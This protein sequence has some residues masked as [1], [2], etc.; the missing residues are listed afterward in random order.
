[1]ENQIKISDSE[2]EI[3]S[4]NNE[5]QL[6]IGEFLPDI[7][8]SEVNREI[9]EEK[10]IYETK[11]NFNTKDN[12]YN[13]DPKYIIDNENNDNENNN[14][15]SCVMYENSIELSN[16]NNLHHLPNHL[17]NLSISNI[18]LNLN[19]N[20]NSN[21]KF[22][23]K[24]SLIDSLE[25]NSLMYINQINHIKNNI[26]SNNIDYLEDK[27][28][29]RKCH[30]NNGIH[31]LA[32]HHKNNTN[33]NSN[34]CISLINNRNNERN[35]TDIERKKVR[36][37]SNII[38]INSHKSS[39]NN[40]NISYVDNK[41]STKTSS[42]MEFSNSYNLF[43]EKFS[44]VKRS[45]I[46]NTNINTNI[47]TNSKNNAN[48]DN[49]KNNNLSSR[50]NSISTSNMITI[51]TIKSSN[52]NNTNNTVT[53]T[54]NGNGENLSKSIQNIYN[55][56]KNEDKYKHLHNPIQYIQTKTEKIILKRQ[57]N[58]NN[59]RSKKSTIELIDSN[60]SIRKFLSHRDI[61]YSNKSSNNINRSYN[62]NIINDDVSNDKYGKRLFSQQTFNSFF[63]VD[64]N[65]NNNSDNINS[66]NKFIKNPNFSNEYLNT[67]ISNYDNRDNK[68]NNDKHIRN[69]CKISNKHSN[70]LF[71]NYNKEDIK[72][73]SF[74]NT[75]NTI[76]NNNTNNNNNSKSLNVNNNFQQIYYTNKY[77]GYIK[78]DADLI[79]DCLGN[80]ISKINKDIKK[81]LENM[82]RETILNR[83]KAEVV[84]IADFS[85][86]NFN[87]KKIINNI[88]FF[89]ILTK[90]D[91]DFS[92]NSNSCFVSNC[93]N[94]DSTGI[95]NAEFNSNNNSEM[96]VKNK[97]KYSNL[98]NN[99]SKYKS[100]SNR[101]FMKY[102]DNSVNNNN[103]SKL[104]H[105]FYS[106]HDN[107]RFLS[108]KAFCNTISN[109]NTIYYPKSNYNNN[110]DAVNTITKNS[111][112]IKS[113]K[114]IKSVRSIA[115]SNYKKASKSL[116]QSQLNDFNFKYISKNNTNCISNNNT[117]TY[118]HDTTTLTKLNRTKTHTNRTS[119]SHYLNKT[120]SSM[121]LL[122]ENREK[123]LN[124]KT[125]I[126]KLKERVKQVQE[127]RYI[128][129][130][131]VHDNYNKN[132]SINR[133]VCLDIKNNDLRSVNKITNEETKNNI[134]DD[135]C[136]D[137]LIN[138]SSH[139][140]H[141]VYSC[142]NGE[143]EN[144]TIRNININR[145][146]RNYDDKNG[147]NVIIVGVDS[148]VSNKINNI[149]AIDFNNKTS[150]N[151]YNDIKWVSNNKLMI[152]E[153][154]KS[155][156]IA[157]TG[158]ISIKTNTI[159]KHSN[160]SLSVIPKSNNNKIPYKKNKNNINRKGFNPEL[161]KELEQHIKENR[162]NIK[163][164]NTHNLTLKENLNI[165]AFKTGLSQS[166]LKTSSIKSNINNNKRKKQL[167][168]SYNNKSLNEI[169]QLLPKT[170]N[171]PLAKV[172]KK[173]DTAFSSRLNTVKMDTNTKSNSY[174]INNI[175]NQS[176]NENLSNDCGEENI[177][178]AEEGVIVNIHNYIRLNSQSP[179][180]L[181]N[182][183]NTEENDNN[184]CNLAFDIKKEVEKDECY[185]RNIP[186]QNIDINNNNSKSNDSNSNFNSKYN[187]ENKKRIIIEDN[188][189]ANINESNISQLKE[190]ETI[191]KSI[192]SNN[193][194]NDSAS[195]NM[196]SNN[197]N[198]DNS[199]G[200]NNHE[201]IKIPNHPQLKKYNTKNSLSK[202]IKTSCTK[203]NIKKKITNN[204]KSININNKVTQHFE[205]F[206]LQ[207]L[208]YNVYHEFS[209][210][211]KINPNTD[212]LERMK[213]YEIKTNVK[214][215]KIRETVEQSL[216]KITEKE[217]DRLVNNL[218][219]DK[220]RRELAKFQSKAKYERVAN[221]Q[222]NTNAS[223]HNWNEYY[224]KN[225]VDKVSSAKENKEKRIKE[226][227]ESKRI[228]EERRIEEIKKRNKIVSKEKAEKIF[229]RLSKEKVKHNK[230]G[231]LG[232]RSDICVNNSNRLNHNVY[233][234][235]RIYSN[236]NTYN[237]FLENI[238][239][240]NAVNNDDYRIK[241]DLLK[242]T[243]NK[244]KF[245]E[246][247]LKKKE[248]CQLLSGL[249]NNVENN[250]TNCGT[251]TEIVVSANNDGYGIDSNSGIKN[252]ASSNSCRIIQY[253]NNVK[254]N[255]KG[256]SN[257]TNKS[258]KSNS[259][260]E[261]NINN[262]K[263]K[264]SHLS[265][266]SDINIHTNETYKSKEYISTLPDIS[267][268][269]S[270]NIIK[271]TKFGAI[272][273]KK[274]INSNLIDKSANNYKKIKIYNSNSNKNNNKSMNIP[275][276]V[277]YNNNN[278]NKKFIKNHMLNKT[279]Y[280]NTNN[281][282]FVKINE[283]VFSP[284]SSISNITT[285]N[286]NNNS[287]SNRFINCSYNNS[288]N[289]KNA[290]GLV[291]FNTKNNYKRSSDSKIKTGTSSDRI[292][293]K[294]I[295]KIEFKTKTNTNKYP[296]FSEFKN[297]F[298][299]HKNN[300]NII[301][302]N[303]NNNNITKNKSSFINN[304]KTTTTITNKPLISNTNN[305]TITNT[306]KEVIVNQSNH[307]KNNS[308]IHEVKLSS[309]NFNNK[310]FSP[311][312]SISN[313]LNNTNNINNTHTSTIINVTKADITKSLV[314][315][316]QINY[317]LDNFFN[318]KQK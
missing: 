291:R 290:K 154:N 285:N 86:K 57:S 91:V 220:N 37:T 205:K 58:V 216:P 277:N 84:G 163:S 149:D 235:N 15:N 237:E 238:V 33:N 72:E 125:E 92:N 242:N 155:Y 106:N 184:R 264:L 100:I 32:F 260:N 115:K 27:N 128:D 18:N 93:F 36:F 26:N 250:K 87:E 147:E 223:S 248:V 275:M 96:N 301:G 31:K 90:E 50:L 267:S 231:S 304:P 42:V 119:S 316:K 30:S 83:F 206:N 307:S 200:N 89:E 34:S 150:N 161:N 287:N 182:K 109:F 292:K 54:Q 122:K 79:T 61:N 41:K 139:V 187:N 265:N 69:N 39:K 271:N 47:N 43:K 9:Q 293:P 158:N 22:L 98:S 142:D 226:S 274:N 218:L 272:K 169:S 133:I 121:L 20:S 129:K 48:K 11:N 65:N 131:N 146:K 309:Y 123:G 174:N 261:I 62:T 67:E 230:K 52:T 75:N 295:S 35:K 132:S 157:N 239:L 118:F 256:S 173:Y 156:S 124:N 117:I 99:N 246:E 127:E 29:L 44:E 241:L 64:N 193:N 25:D 207:N 192:Y 280:L 51:K 209:H 7:S 270:N 306:N 297:L 299:N 111:N 196:H 211:N 217:K 194:I 95:T 159:N 255:I 262:D 269:N 219:E 276:S 66:N 104:N 140:D 116:S 28:N 3:N 185:I 165:R 56:V 13:R 176:N 266:N 137:N 138:C 189:T 108:N 71:L 80:N 77:E 168:Y 166:I 114:S 311:I 6:N 46:N 240:M 282:E 171:Y 167:N 232:L 195:N 85:N 14:N 152:K 263:N 236:N 298:S 2:N 162:S 279:N 40:N 313:Y 300:N 38:R 170:E 180:D 278:N 45:N 254:S 178:H 201:F 68:D 130:S 151:S 181:I 78:E 73:I 257:M 60:K 136:T 244:Y 208:S 110:I 55:Q 143:N 308:N 179:S 199:K 21:S 252:K 82:E 210:K 17:N 53:N 19:N 245:V 63:K 175:S 224:Q 177:S 286:D 135:K 302:N 294:V 243:C 134:K 253:N 120:K 229:E 81:Q 228:E 76:T 305:K 221:K 310:V 148:N 314:P 49:I 190:K 94:K 303:S 70:S 191:F 97:I 74:H 4:E 153:L 8:I 172:L 113:I 288:V 23:I 281:E 315:D 101:R 160:N 183:I 227:L 312:N 283:R 145:N 112:T 234:S 164:S 10:E 284:I 12:N 107:S 317:I 188:V 268:D 197:I 273:L 141:T 16:N 103:S 186:S 225:F 249:L 251:N 198:N 213:Y 144:E 258:M 59:S 296:A 1:M 126:S 222:Y 102:V 212:F 5:N 88:P 202:T 215:E 318:K 24:R 203:V 289:S 204:N 259:K 233:S 214:N 247:D 105:N